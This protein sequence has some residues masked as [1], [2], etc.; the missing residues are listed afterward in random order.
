M[1]LFAGV[2]FSDCRVVLLAPLAALVLN[3]LVRRQS[4]ALLL[5]IPYW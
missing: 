1:T 5:K 3:D 2:Q 4:L